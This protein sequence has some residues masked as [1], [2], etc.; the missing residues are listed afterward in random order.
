MLKQDSN[1]N[2][3]IGLPKVKLLQRLANALA[4]T[5]Y[6]F[7]FTYK[8]FVSSYKIALVK[9][10]KKRG[11]NIS[12]IA[13]QAELDRRFVSKFFDD[14]HTVSTDRNSARFDVLEK[15][16]KVQNECFHGEPLPMKDFIHIVKNHGDGMVI[17]SPKSFLK[18][19]CSES[20]GCAEDLKTH[21]NIKSLCLNGVSNIDELCKLFS[22]NTDRYIDAIEQNL[23]A[24]SDER[25]LF[26]R[27]VSSTKVHPNR[28]DEINKFAYQ[29]KF[30]EN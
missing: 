24:S 10:G 15:L 8:Q 13:T 23:S 7:G 2:T 3:I 6:L 29:L 19:I 26:E 18:L 5:T 1:T 22:V 21:V 4:K 16:Y 17:S 20:V 11:F 30:P 9:E 25:K 14:S 28:H 27:V 12:D